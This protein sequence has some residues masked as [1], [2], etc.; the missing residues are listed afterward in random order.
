MCGYK[1][2]SKAIRQS[3]Q[4]FLVWQ[5]PPCDFWGLALTSCGMSS[6]YLSRLSEPG[7]PPV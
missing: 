1:K 7:F 5:R 2:V 3:G 6:H 4:A